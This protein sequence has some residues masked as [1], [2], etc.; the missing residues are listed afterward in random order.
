MAGLKQG[1]IIFD[2]DDTLVYSHEQFLLAESSFA[3]R[4]SELGLYDEALL[5]AARER[6]ILNVRRVGYMAAEC[7]PLALLQTYESYCGKY[8]RAPDANEMR[9]LLLLGWQPY[10]NPPREMEGGRELLEHLR[11]PEGGGRTLI[12]FTQGE[13][14]IQQQRL[15]LCNLA[16][17][18]DVVKVSREKNDAELMALLKEQNL[19]PAFTWYVGNSLLHDINPAIRAGLNAVHLITGGWSYEDEKPCGPYHSISNLGQFADILHKAE[20]AR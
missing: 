14:E 17:M 15:N 9:L 13:Q 11:S 2:F 19:E 7:F 20:V 16:G 18:F 12:L 6:D 5:P 4:M 1:G 8:G 10:V 3:A